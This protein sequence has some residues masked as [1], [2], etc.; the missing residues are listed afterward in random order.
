MPIVTNSFAARKRDIDGEMLS[1]MGQNQSFS[2]ADAWQGFK[3]ENLVWMGGVK[4]YDLLTNASAAKWK[5]KSGL[6][7]FTIFSK[8]FR[9]LI[10]SK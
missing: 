2:F 9:F 7:S 1:S 8:D 3:D 5:I 6:T 10:S 4:L